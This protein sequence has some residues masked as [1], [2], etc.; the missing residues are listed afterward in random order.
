MIFSQ[1]RSCRYSNSL[2]SKVAEK[3]FATMQF[4]SPRP[5]MKSSRLH[6][7]VRLYINECC[8]VHP[9]Y[10]SDSCSASKRGIHLSSRCGSCLPSL[11]FEARYA[12][13]LISTFRLRSLNILLQSST[14]LQA[15]KLQN[16]F[17]LTPKQGTR[18]KRLSLPH[19]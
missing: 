16:Y 19:D 7:K 12:P 6:R 14:P 4:A 10:Q 18:P 17:N 9:I 13:T 8:V 5:I 1:L 2:L 11:L 15:S 3:V